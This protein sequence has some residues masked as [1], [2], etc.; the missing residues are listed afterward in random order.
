MV[1]SFRSQP[2]RFQTQAQTGQGFAHGVHISQR[3]RC[4]CTR[5]CAMQDAW[6]PELA[7]WHAGKLMLRGQFS[8]TMRSKGGQQLHAGMMLL[9]GQMCSTYR[10]VEDVRPGDLVDLDVDATDLQLVGGGE[11]ATGSSVTMVLVAVGPRGDS[12]A[13]RKTQVDTMSVSVG[14][15]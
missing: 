7:V 4:W 15:Q 11:R 6:T 12:C 9:S 13:R 3:A 1:V 14:N 2:R 8:Q 5:R 10:G